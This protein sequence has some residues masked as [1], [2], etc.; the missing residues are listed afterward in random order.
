MRRGRP[1]KGA[2]PAP[3]SEATPPSNNRMVRTGLAS[4]GGG[5]ERD[6]SS[7]EGMSSAVGNRSTPISPAQTAVNGGFGDS[8]SAFGGRA[9]FGETFK[10]QTPSPPPIS[11]AP[12]PSLGTASVLF[13]DLVSPSHSSGG[14]SPSNGSANAGFD[15][16]RNGKS[17]T[18]SMRPST[19]SSD[20]SKFDK[21]AA[22]TPNYN[23]LSLSSKPSLP[24]SFSTSSFSPSPPAQSPKPP[25]LTGA[26]DAGPPLPRRPPVAS[27]PA[28]VQSPLPRKPEK[29]ELVNRASQTSPHLMASWKP[30]PSLATSSLKE[31]T[32]PSHA[33]TPSPTLEG[34][35]LPTIVARKPVVDL[36]GDDEDGFGPSPIARPQTAPTTGPAASSDQ[37]RPTTMSTAR[38]RMLLVGGP[39]EFNFEASRGKFRPTRPSDAAPPAATLGV[40]GKSP[41]GY[42]SSFASSSSSFDRKPSLE[43]LEAKDRFPSLDDLDARSPTPPP[44]SVPTPVSRAGTGTQ[45]NEWQP[46]VEKEDESSDDDPEEFA[47]KRIGR[48]GETP[49]PRSK[50]KPSV[51]QAQPLVSSPDQHARDFANLPPISRVESSEDEGDIDLGPALASIRRFAPTSNNGPKLEPTQEGWSASPIPRQTSSPVIQAPRPQTAKRQAAISSLVSR[52]ETISSDAP[53]SGRTSTDGKR[54]PPPAKPASLR[55]DSTESAHRAHPSAAS[56]SSSSWASPKADAEGFHQRFPDSEGLDGHFAASLPLP[57]EPSPALSSPPPPHVPPKVAPKRFGQ[58]PSPASSLQSSHSGPARLPF[59]PVPLPLAPKSEEQNEEEEKFV[60]VSNMRSRWE[61]MGT[62]GRGTSGPPPTGPGKPAVRKEW[63]VV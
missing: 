39:S 35:N 37:G 57:G 48:A 31:S 59:K 19:S 9:S 6:K 34:F 52:Y 29:P 60:G 36:L 58:Q 61:G 40:M 1:S 51:L 16:W 32:V 23:L 47:P 22:F 5:G 4:V 3:P 24:T 25:Q 15:A 43:K 56:S 20:S 46:I 28:P 2:G 50:P 18:G 44:L 17:A 63:G 7:W 33:L 10:S 53:V 30:P 41:S 14:L 62:G 8:F 26:G 11:P 21:E 45:P 12:S 27:S 38:K 42:T 13:S 49:A 55:K 54:P